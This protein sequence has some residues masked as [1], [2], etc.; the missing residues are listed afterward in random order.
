MVVLIKYASKSKQAFHSYRLKDHIFAMVCFLCTAVYWR[1]KSWLYENGETPN[2]FWCHIF[3]FEIFRQKIRTFSKPKL[4]L[5]IPLVSLPIG[6]LGP[7]LKLESESFP[8]ASQQPFVT[9]VH[10]ATRIN[11]EIYLFFIPLDNL[12]FNIMIIS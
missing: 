12:C 4:R 1:S 7:T 8:E 10:L 3:E 9:K 2:I 11:P 5:L 6:D